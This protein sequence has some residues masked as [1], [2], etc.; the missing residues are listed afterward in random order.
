[1]HLY[2]TALPSLACGFFICGA[3]MH[4]MA[5]VKMKYNSHKG[6]AKRRGIEFKMT[7]DEW[8]GLWEPYWHNR[9][10][11][12]GQYVMCRTM[13][14]GPYEIGNVRIDTPKGNGRTRRIVNHEKVVHERQMAYVESEPEDS[15]NNN[16]WLPEELIGYHTLND[17]YERV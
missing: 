5:D 9:G 6:G 1:L 13:D 3:Y 8:W 4:N 17:Y 7:F 14:R 11:H 16:P 10:S 12:A 2:Q 15:E